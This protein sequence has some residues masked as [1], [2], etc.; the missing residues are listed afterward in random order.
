VCSLLPKRL[1]VPPP[2]PAPPRNE[3]DQTRHSKVVTLSDFDDPD[4]DPW[5]PPTD[6]VAPACD[7]YRAG[8]AVNLWEGYDASGPPTKVTKKGEWTCPRHGS[9]CSPGICE[10]RARFK[11][12]KRMKN[13]REKWEEERRQ[14]EAQKAMD[15][16]IRGR[17]KAEAM[18]EGEG[19]SEWRSP[20]LRLCRNASSGT[21]TSTSSGLDSDNSH[22]QGTVSL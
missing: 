11:R 22:K 17:K 13:A 12:D 15:Q 20:P 6:A 8:S 18:G 2:L 5:N 1:T 10:E 7:Q 21:S 19:E 16:P 14:R 9:L 3:E 4:Y